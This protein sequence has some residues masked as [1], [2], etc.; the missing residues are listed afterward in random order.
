MRGAAVMSG[1]APAVGLDR[2]I[3]VAPKGFHCVPVLAAEWAGNAQRVR[4]VTAVIH[5]YPVPALVVQ[6]GHVVLAVVRFA[7]QQLPGCL[8]TGEHL[9]DGHLIV[10]L[11]F[12]APQAAARTGIQV[13]LFASPSR[14]PTQAVV[15]GAAGRVTQNGI[16]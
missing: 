7:D 14:H 9:C 3:T 10:Q 8:L 16:G 1:E 11:A 5:A 15:D 4:T 12:E 2:L 6:R 13:P